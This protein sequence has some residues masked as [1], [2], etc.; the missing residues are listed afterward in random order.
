MNLLEFFRSNKTKAYDP[1]HLTFYI[2][3]FRWHMSRDMR[4]LTMW[5][6][7]MC[8]LRRACA[9]FFIAWKIQMMF[10]Q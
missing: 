10:S 6:F 3:T 8:R 4:F 7:D 5:H 9:A 1:Y 2:P